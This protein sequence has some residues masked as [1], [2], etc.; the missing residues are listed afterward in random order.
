MNVIRI[1]W[2]DL[3]QRIRSILIYGVLMT[4]LVIFFASFFDPDLFAEFEEIMDAFPPELMMMFGE[5]TNLGTIDGFLHM[6]VMSLAWAWFG[7]FFLMR[8]AQDIPSDIETKTIEITLSKSIQRWEYIL[9]K[10]L[11]HVISVFIVL[12]MVWGVLILYLLA[13]PEYEGYYDIGNLTITFFWL[14]LFLSTLVSTALLLS[15]ILGSKKAVGIAFGFLIIMFFIGTFWS[16]FPEASQNLKYI[17]VFYYF[18]SSELLG[19]GIMDDVARDMGILA[20]YTVVMIGLATLVF[21]KRDI[22]V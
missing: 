19:F 9:A 3:R 2:N 21:Q 18:E 5:Q 15:T 8:A 16:S 1:F 11:Y 7:I 12:L 6:E 14:W 20:V 4:L 22:P 17:S 10:A 13:I